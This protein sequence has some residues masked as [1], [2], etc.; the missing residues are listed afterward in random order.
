[1]KATLTKSQKAIILIHT[2]WVGGILLATEDYR[3]PATWVVMWSLPIIIYW[4]GVWI[5]GF[6]YIRKSYSLLIAKIS[7]S[8]DTEP[9]KNEAAISSQDPPRSFNKFARV[10]EYVLNYTIWLLIIAGLSYI[11]FVFNHTDI[12][13]TQKLSE[14]EITQKN[15]SSS[16][17]KLPFGLR[18]MMSKN[19]ALEQMKTLEQFRI[20]PAEEDSVIYRTYAPQ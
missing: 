19:Q 20:K 16:D 18:F 13:T 2:A 12:Q 10:S 9:Q 5:W 7:N 4:A 1:M 17:F 15:A 14:Y 3:R 11:I 6:G 8:E